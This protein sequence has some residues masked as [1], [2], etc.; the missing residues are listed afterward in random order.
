MDKIITGRIVYFSKQERFMR[1]SNANSRYYVM[2]THRQRD[3]FSMYLTEGVFVSLVLSNK[4]EILDGIK[5]YI[6][7]RFMKIAKIKHYD[8]INMF[9]M[10]DVRSVERD[11]MNRK[12]YRLFIDMEFTMPPLSYNKLIDKPF[13]AEI[14]EFGYALMD[15]SYNVIE[16]GYMLILPQKKKALND[17]TLE[18]CDL[19]LKEFDDAVKYISFYSFLEHII[20]TYHPRIIHWGKNDAL[21]LERSYR[22]NNVKPLK[23]KSLMLNLMSVMK[24]YYH[25]HKDLGLFNTFSLLTQKPLEEQSHNAL[26]DAQVL[27]D[28]FML[29]KE[30]VNKGITKL[31][32]NEGQHHE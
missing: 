3:S 11:I 9:D 8:L 13:T 28:I 25:L 29:F 4:Y 10:N 7:D 19:N 32:D 18:F 23:T 21:Q 16:Q 17:R 5:C 14:V 30:V 31:P 26:E 22:L 15:P 24:N 27:K 2:M 1:I 12:E 6:I 20:K